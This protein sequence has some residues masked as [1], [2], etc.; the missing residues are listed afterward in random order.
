MVKLKK[1]EANNDIVKYYYIAE[2]SESKGVLAYYPKTGTK[3]VEKYCGGDSE[4]SYMDK[5]RA[6]AF[7]RLEQY[8]TKN[9]YPDEDMVFWG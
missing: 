7:H 6:H 1:I 8:A 5:H 4:D 2:D 9:N 3:K